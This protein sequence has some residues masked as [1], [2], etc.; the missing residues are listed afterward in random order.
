MLSVK[1]G[2]KI[3]SRLEEMCNEAITPETI[4]KFSANE[5]QAIGTLSAKAHYIKNLAKS[6]ISIQNKCKK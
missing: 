1:A 5:I 4:N 2:R 3:Y 6:D